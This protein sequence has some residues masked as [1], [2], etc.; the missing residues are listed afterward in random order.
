MVERIIEKQDAIRVVLGQDRKVSHL[1][2]NWQ[3]LMFCNLCWR[4]LEVFKDLT[5]LS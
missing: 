4:L 2:S 5:D 3:D 1:V